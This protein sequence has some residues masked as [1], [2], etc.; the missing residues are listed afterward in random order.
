[1]RNI[2]RLQ[3][4]ESVLGMQNARHMLDVWPRWTQPDVYWVRR[5]LHEQGKC[6]LTDA[7]TF[8]SDFMQS[9][10]TDL[11]RRHLTIIRQLAEIVGGGVYFVRR[12]ACCGKGR[13]DRAVARVVLKLGSEFVSDDVFLRLDLHP[14]GYGLEK[15]VL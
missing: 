4:L 7:V 1:M 2:T 13:I 6:A 9:S 15:V 12:T 3:D 10:M 11:E 5:K 8:Q 14:A